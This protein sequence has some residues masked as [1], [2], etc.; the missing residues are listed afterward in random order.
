[1]ASQTSRVYYNVKNTAQMTTLR[2]RNTVQ[3]EA[4]TQGHR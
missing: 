1:M 2:D 4:K 3:T